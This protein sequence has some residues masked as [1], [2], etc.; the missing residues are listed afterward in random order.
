MKCDMHVHSL[1]SGMM[2]SP[3]FLRYVC[4][5]SYSP[6]EEVYETLKRRGMHLVT[7]TDHDSIDGAEGLR[8]KPDFFV[9][10]EVTVR[11]PSGTEFHLAVY[12]LAER[13][14][15]EIQRRRNDLDALLAYL[16]EQRL[17]FSVNH[18]FSS[19]TGAR[20]REDFV[21]FTRHSPAFETRNGHQL[22]VSNRLAARLARQLNRVCLGGSDAH[23]LVSLAS[24]YTT[25]EGARNKADFLD[26]LRR[27]LGRA[28]GGSGGYWKLTRDGLV[29]ANSLMSEWPSARLFTPFLLFLPLFTLAHYWNEL[30]FARRW[31]EVA[32]DAG[33]PTCTRTQNTKS[34]SRSPGSPRPAEQMG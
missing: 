21:W 23:T 10:E 32:R 22:P 34:T 13:Q 12:D 5:E 16:S 3:F 31:R 18:A 27:G 19:L 14:H 2:P 33:R 28:R 24:A 4:R 30:A 15:V 29:V 26:G 8:C 25:V 9:S 7:L 11:M 1:H 6:P 17:L 20:V